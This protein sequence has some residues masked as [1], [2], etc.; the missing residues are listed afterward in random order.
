MFVALFS[1]SFYHTTTSE[2]MPSFGFVGDQE[3][4][5]AV[6]PAKPKQNGSRMSDTALGSK[7]EIA[8]VAVEAALDD[9]NVIF[10]PSARRLP[11]LAIEVDKE[12]YLVAKE[13]F[14]EPVGPSFW[15]R[16]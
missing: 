8:A 4:S 12:G 13:G 15:E 14:Q 11:Q 10:G 5:S 1:I 16:G 7:D 9:G 2:K 6:S 3:V